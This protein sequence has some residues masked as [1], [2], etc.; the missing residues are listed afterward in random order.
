MEYAVMLADYLRL[1]VETANVD[2]VLLTGRLFEKSLY[3][4]SL[5]TQAEEE[6]YKAAVMVIISQE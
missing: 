6:E 4:D 2:T 3:S 5:L 1:N